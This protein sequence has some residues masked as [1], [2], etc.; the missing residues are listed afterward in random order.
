MNR[1]YKEQDR[2]IIHSLGPSYGDSEFSGRVVGIA[3]DH[4]T[5]IYIIKLDDPSE[6]CSDYSCVTFPEGCLRPYED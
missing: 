4:I 5:K 1:F 6:F 2:V 3:F